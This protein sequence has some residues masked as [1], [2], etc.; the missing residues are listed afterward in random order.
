MNEPE[1]VEQNLTIPKKRGNPA[2]VKGVSGNPKGPPQ[3]PEIE[4]LRQAI[5]AAR[6][7]NGNRSILFH[8]V[9]RAYFN[10]AVL[11]AL[12][13]KLIPD[14]IHKDIGIDDDLRDLIGQKIQINFIGVTPNGNQLP[15][16]R[17]VP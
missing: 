3:N 11:I 12:I 5:R 16:S 2:W 14:K 1:I 17:Q 8:F 4:E 9:E 15:D 13:K 10:D 6:K 7:K